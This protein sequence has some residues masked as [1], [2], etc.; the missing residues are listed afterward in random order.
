[1]LKKIV[2][3]VAVVALTF[4]I[5]LPA[6]AAS[7]GTDGQATTLSPGILCIWFGWC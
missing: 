4:G 2:I 7:K 3:G 1:M 6:S 5:A